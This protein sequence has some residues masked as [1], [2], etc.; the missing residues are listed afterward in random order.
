[1]IELPNIQIGSIPSFVIWTIIL[2][3]FF[4]AVSLLTM[5]IGY[6]L[7]K[8]EKDFGLKL[9]RIAIIPTIVFGVLLFISI[10]SECQ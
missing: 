2:E 9:F 4:L 5:I 3:T 8:R 6:H 10:I 1:M 7:S